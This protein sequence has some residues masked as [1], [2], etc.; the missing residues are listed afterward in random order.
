[1]AKVGGEGKDHISAAGTELIE[2]ASG[3]VSVLGSSPS[4]W[5]LVTEPKATGAPTAYTTEVAHAIVEYVACGG[6][7]TS[8]CKGKGYGPSKRPPTST[9]NSWSS[10]GREGHR[11]FRP[12]FGE[13]RLAYEKAKELRSEVLGELQID[14][15]SYAEESRDA[16]SKA[17]EIASSLRWMAE[18][19]APEKWGVKQNVEVTGKNGGAIKIET[20]SDL[21]TA[22]VAEDPKIVEAEFT[23]ADDAEI[24]EGD[25]E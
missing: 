7:L 22:A 24:V 15:V 20:F 11:D 1:M 18:R 10:A 23:L 19:S 9:V 8:W 6:T 25:D 2:S 16:I 12:H 17:R 21:L 3:H 4:E 5:G 14:V 13:F